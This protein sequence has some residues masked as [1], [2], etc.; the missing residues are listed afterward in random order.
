MRETVIAG[1]GIT[2][3][4]HYPDLPTSATVGE[5]TLKA[6]KDAGLTWNDIQAAYCGDEDQGHASG[7]KAFYELGQKGFPIVKTESACAS[8]MVAFRL[9]FQAVS[10]GI[11]DTVIAVGFEKMP[12]GAIPSTAFR[13][14]QIKMGFNFQPANYCLEMNEYMKEHELTSTDVSNVV[15]RARKYSQYNPYARYQNLVTLEQV[16]N[17]KIVCGQVKL[18]QCSATSDGAVAFV[19]TTRDKA[20]DK[21]RAVTIKAMSM[22]SGFYGI[23]AYQCGLIQSMIHPPKQSYHE[24]AAKQ[25][26]EYAGVGPEDIDVMQAYDSMAVAMIWDLEAMGFARSGEAAG[27]LR[28]GYFEIDGKLPVNLDGGIMGRGHAIGASGMAQIY[29]I[30]LQLRG[31][32]GKTQ[33]PKHRIGMAHCSGAGPSSVVGIFA[34]NN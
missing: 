19:I 31:E 23:S 32:A 9:A 29:N 13:D 25:A 24:L 7:H 8:G 21:K 17:S 33:A 4:G 2:K 22:T 28:D 34:G 1:T 18:Y 15:V 26:Y 3:F 10:S 20:K 27:L 14:Y 6:L 12:P 5:A 11:Y 16:E 30:A